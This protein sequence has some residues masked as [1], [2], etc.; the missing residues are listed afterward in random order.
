MIETIC[1]DCIFA[2]Y[3]IVPGWDMT[4]L[5]QNGCELGRITKFTEFGCT[6]LQSEELLNS[7][8]QKYVKTYNR[9]NR[10]CNTCRNEKWVHKNESRTSAITRVKQETSSRFQ[11]FVFIT[12]QSTDQEILNTYQ[13]L[14]QIY[15][16]PIYIE[17]I[18]QDQS[19]TLTSL[20]SVLNRATSKRIGYKINLL[21]EPLDRWEVV[22]KFLRKDNYSFFTVCHTG[23]L[24]YETEL[25]K[26]ELAVNE[27][28][29]YVYLVERNDD[30]GL[31]INSAVYSMV[32]NSSSKEENIVN[33]IKSLLSQ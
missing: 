17:F 26:I 4:M 2:T 33:K 18:I 11:I 8:Q 10:L 25:A 28:L 13:S 1:R 24:Y 21:I 19:Y 23:Y 3:S 12:K 20:Q 6:Q 15:R 9:I 7:N 14:C 27:D 31:I 29:N 22:D 5:E 16:I 32:R 30:N